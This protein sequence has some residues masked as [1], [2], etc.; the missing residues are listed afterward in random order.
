MARSANLSGVHIYARELVD[1]KFRTSL[2][3]MPVLL[4]ALDRRGGMVGKLG[5]KS[6][7]VGAIIS[8]ARNMS[9]N[10]LTTTQGSTQRQIRFNT[11][12][13]GGVKYL[14][15]DDTTASTGTARQDSKFQS[16]YVSWS[17]AEAPISVR[18]STLRKAKGPHELANPI[19]IAVEQ[20][21]R[22]LVDQVGGDV[23]TGSPTDQTAEDWDAPLGLQQW[24]HSSNTI[25]GIDRSSVSGFSGNRVT[26]A[27]QAKLSLID[28]ANLDY[29]G[30]GNGVANKGGRIDL[31]LAGNIL[32][33]KMKDEALARGYQLVKNDVQERGQVGL[34]LEGFEY[35]GAL[36]TLDPKAPASSV[37]MLDSR[38][39]LMEIMASENWKVHKFNDL[40]EN[41]P[42]GSPD[43]TISRVSL[44][45]RLVVERPWENVQYTNVS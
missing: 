29:D 7:N 11:G 22:E 13:V 40:R 33:K 8:G 14:G 9:K 24:I 28:E 37:F 38:S 1:S 4:T 42:H 44:G 3:D 39:V 23:Y 43:L 27:K 2:F 5:D 45:Y 18:N 31:V 36:V 21:M 20:A 6:Q 10:M 41:G 34:L 12:T 30:S 26:G 25:G 16:A 35:N 17:I 32:Y 15:T 19:E